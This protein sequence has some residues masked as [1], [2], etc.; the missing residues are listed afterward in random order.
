M[1]ASQNDRASVNDQALVTRQTSSTCFLIFYFCFSVLSLPASRGSVWFG[2][3]FIL[4]NLLVNTLL[5]LIVLI[6]G[7]GFGS[8]FFLTLCSGGLWPAVMAFMA[9]EAMR[10]PEE[11][12]G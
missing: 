5:F 2:S 12:R 11:E 7:Y 10:E 3:T 6:F 4:I 8:N 1:A 9:I